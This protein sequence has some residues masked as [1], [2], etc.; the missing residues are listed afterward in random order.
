MYVFVVSGFRGGTDLGNGISYM[1]G[2]LFV[3][4]CEMAGF[5][6]MIVGV[7]MDV[8]NKDSYSVR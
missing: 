4:V 1:W 7:N 3:T 8:Y 2:V 5:E 6:M